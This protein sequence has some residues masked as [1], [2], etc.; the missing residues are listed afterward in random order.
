M[1]KKSYNKEEI[2][3]KLY[4][5]IIELR[6]KP[7]DIL[8]EEEIGEMFNVSRTPVREVLKRLEI[9]GYIKVISKHGNKVT[10]IDSEAVKQIEAMRGIL[11]IAIMKELLFKITLEQ[12]D[13]L[14][15]NI[16]MQQEIIKTGKVDAF[17]EIDNEFHRKMFLFAGREYWWNNIKRSE[18]HYMRFRMLEMSSIADIDL[19]FV[20]HKTL[21][22]ILKDR[23]LELIEDAVKAHLSCTTYRLPLLI[24]KYPD[25]FV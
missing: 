22:L 12:L 13:E 10:M 18:P 25:Y 23:R 5:D 7:N 20:Q 16:D 11:E 9:E 17:W 21:F 8:K 14:K 15:E 4:D 6:Y 19:L 3:S 1:N 24:E 2:Y